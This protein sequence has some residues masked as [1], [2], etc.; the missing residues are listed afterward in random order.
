[1]P[2]SSVMPLCGI[3]N[4]LPTAQ[5]GAWCRS[6]SQRGSSA[7]RPE[8]SPRSGC[9]GAILG[10]ELRQ[11]ASRRNV[12][13]SLRRGAVVDEQRDVDRLGRARDPQHLA[14]D[15]VFANDERVGAEPLDRFA[16][17]STALTNIVRSRTSRR[18]GTRG[19]WMQ[20]TVSAANTAAATTNDRI[21]VKRMG[22]CR[23]RLVRAV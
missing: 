6:C 12:I 13:S 18:P 1:M 23:A 20:R 19:A 9:R 14:A 22:V 21:S 2:S 11:G 16:L 17:A 7:D 10:D 5:S 3:A 15:A 8:R 4:K